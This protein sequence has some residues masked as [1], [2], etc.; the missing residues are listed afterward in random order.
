VS[1]RPPL[2]KLILAVHLLI[3]VG[4]IGAAI[5]YLALALA[6]RTDGEVTTV[7]SAWTAMELIGWWVLVPLSIGT[8]ITGVLLAIG[9]S[10]GLFRHYWVVI[11]LTLTTLATGVLLLH[12]PDV[13]DQAAAAQVADAAGLEALGSDL[14]HSGLGLLVLVAILVLN[15]CKPRGLTR[16]GWRK[17]QEQRGRPEA[18]P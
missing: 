13:S 18:A 9:T 14:F 3:S 15:V 6:V 7:R 1:L 8:M 10:W 17:N 11:S 16:Y 2:R 4:W 12:M 5:A